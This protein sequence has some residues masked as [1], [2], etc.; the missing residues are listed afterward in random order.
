MLAVLEAFPAGDPVVV[1][2]DNLESA[3]NPQAEAL[4][5]PTLHEVLC[6]VLTAPAHAVTVI[7]TTRVPPTALLTVEPARQRKLPLEKG[8]GSPDA[9]TCCASSTTMAA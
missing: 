2:L 6:A 5:E 4:S 1:L 9:Q 8:L 3:M 7:A